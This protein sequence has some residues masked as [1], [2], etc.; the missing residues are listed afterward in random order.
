MKTYDELVDQI[1]IED[2]EGAVKSAANSL[3]KEEVEFPIGYL[4]NQSLMYLAGY[5]A[6]NHK[7]TV[8]RVT[9]FII[10]NSSHKKAREE[11]L[12]II[13]SNYPVLMPDVQLMSIREPIEKVR[14]FYAK[15]P[16]TF[17]L[18]P[19]IMATS[20]EDALEKARQYVDSWARDC[21]HPDA[22]IS[23]G[24]GLKEVT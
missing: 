8:D 17:T 19:T 4:V 1:P 7:V 24:V 21:H 9:N 5:T 15:I 10:D 18:M 20:K 23:G 11:S 6:E 13:N 22:C 2:I 12:F 16:I 3:P 14:P